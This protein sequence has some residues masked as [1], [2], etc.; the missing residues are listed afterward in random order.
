MGVRRSISRRHLL[1][2]P[3]KTIE[4]VEVT[5]DRV[6]L[7]RH[8]ASVDQSGA[9]DDRNPLIEDLLGPPAVEQRGRQPLERFVVHRLEISNGEKPIDQDLRLSAGSVG[10]G[11]YPSFLW[12]SG[13]RPRSIVADRGGR[14]AARAVRWADCVSP[15][16]TRTS[17]R[18]SRSPSP[19]VA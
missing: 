3:H 6:G 17:E 7:S 5:A 14:R 18:R 15:W 13:G 2:R 8:R 1:R 16:S 9:L 12:Y 4:S 19:Q 10:A 11:R